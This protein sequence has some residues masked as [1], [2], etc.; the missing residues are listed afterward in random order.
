MW[1][2]SVKIAG[3]SS[4]KL[5]PLGETTEVVFD[6]GDVE[7][8]RVGSRKSLKECK[9]FEKRTFFAA[10]SKNTTYIVDISDLSKQA[11]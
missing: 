11:N 9:P 7:K 3:Q 1:H 2:N 10:T 8:N 4:G 6:G 5:S